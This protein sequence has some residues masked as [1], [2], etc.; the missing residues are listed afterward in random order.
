M[1]EGGRQQTRECQ[2]TQLPVITIRTTGDPAFLT[3]FLMLQFLFDSV[4]FLLCSKNVIKLSCSLEPVLSYALATDEN[5]KSGQELYFKICMLIISATLYVMHAWEV[6]CTVPQIR[7]YIHMIGIPPEL[8]L[9]WVR[10][11]DT[12]CCTNKGSHINTLHRC[13]WPPATIVTHS[14]TI[15]R[16]CHDS[17]FH[18][19]LSN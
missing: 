10:R 12:T 6:S 16:S 19:A 14:C 15:F 3:K 18:N 4:I 9:L 7:W 17:Q 11:Q 5:L 1:T 8:V 2:K 13:H